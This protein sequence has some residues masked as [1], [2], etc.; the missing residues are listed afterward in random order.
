[1]ADDDIW[2]PSALLE[3]VHDRSNRF[4]PQQLVEVDFMPG[5]AW[6]LCLAAE[7][8]VANQFPWGFRDR[9]RSSY[10]DDFI[11]SLMKRHA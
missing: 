6:F 10:R 4:C 11:A 7:F 1:M 9:L 2:N 8:V 3:L 5:M